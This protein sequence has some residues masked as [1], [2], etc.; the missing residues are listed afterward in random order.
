MS[1]HLNQTAR[2]QEVTIS[3]VNENMSLISDLSTQSMDKVTDNLKN[4]STLNSINQT[5]TECISGYKHS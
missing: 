4:V 3:S 2:Q 5:L 1:D